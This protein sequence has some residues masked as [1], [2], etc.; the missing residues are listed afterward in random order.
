MKY[1]F[2]VIVSALVLSG[3]NSQPFLT[4]ERLQRGL[5]IVLPGIE[6]RGLFNESICKGLDDGGVDWAIELYDWTSSFVP[7]YN[8]RA[9]GRNRRKASELALRIAQ[10]RLD[11]PDCPVILVGQSG[12]GAIAIWTAE[13]LLPGKQVDGI[14]LL[15]ASLSPEYVLDF[16][17]ERSHRGIVNLYSSRDWVFLGVGTMVYGTMDGRHSASAGQVGF[18]VPTSKKRAE[19]YK[20][21]YQ[22][23]WRPRMS[24]TGHSGIH[25]TS[26]AALYV[27]R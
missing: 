22:L 24:E 13:T 20:K 16:A 5:V 11:Y 23:A 2:P 26:G 17:L 6:G 8:L 25:L 3:C 19:A 21:L 4:P 14:I 1:V 18:E 27:A 15:A 9:Q 10:Y 7:F 12:G